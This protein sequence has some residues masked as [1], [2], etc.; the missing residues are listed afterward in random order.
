MKYQLVLEWIS[1]LLSIVFL[2]CQL[3]LIGVFF[4]LYINSTWLLW[5]IPGA[6]VLIYWSIV[7]FR[8][9]K[10]ATKTDSNN[11]R[12]TMSLCYITWLI[13]CLNLIPQVI[14][15]FVNVTDLLERKFYFGP[16]MLKLA[17]SCTPFLFVVFVYAH[18]NR[19]ESQFRNYYVGYLANEVTL[20]LFDGVE[21]LENLFVDDEEF[22]VSLSIKVILLILSSINFLL[23]AIALY[24][25]HMSRRSNQVTFKIIYKICSLIVLNIPF[26]IL[27]IILWRR[28]HKDISVLF[29][30]NI[31][32]TALNSDELLHYYFIER[33]ASPDKSATIP[34][35]GVRH[36]ESRV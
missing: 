31:I 3:G 35:Q 17:L 7:T 6:I 24:D 16:R 15:L 33:H 5:Y 4:S 1:F 26:L 28:Y 32:I 34:H 11:L 8:P 13:Y 25:L 29:M 2:S 36:I 18:H 9:I 22:T 23:P 19:N 12:D 27:R 21:I 14:L 10:F 30:K 20:D